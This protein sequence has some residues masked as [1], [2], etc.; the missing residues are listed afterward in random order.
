MAEVEKT[1]E[2]PEAIERDFK[3]KVA[4]E[5]QVTSEGID[6]FVV[7][8]PVTFGDGDLLPIVLRKKDD[9]W[10]LTDEAHTFLQLSYR[11]SDE[12]LDQPP[13]R[14][15][16]DR[17]LSSFEIEDRN[18]ELILPI[19]DQ[20]YGNALYTFIQALLKIDDIRYL[21]RERVQST[22]LQDVRSYLE[23][24]VSPQRIAVNW[25]D[26]EK[27]FSGNYPVD[28]RI[29][30]MK[31][32]VFIFAINSEHKADISTIS[33]LKFE[34]WNLKYKSVGIFDEMEN[35]SQKTIAR[36]V[37]ACGKAYSNLEVAKESLQRFVPELSSSDS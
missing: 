6:R 20:Q 21:S 34:Q 15:L 10:Y 18:G 19:P 12:E 35:F 11:L 25:H 33:L 22:F 1:T 2:S 3:A 27:D 13:R 36:F 24:V 14:E 37:D 17:I 23:K 9:L 16:I 28:Y 32:P 31:T 30:G 29:N 5:L 26:P 8:T 4:G 7:V